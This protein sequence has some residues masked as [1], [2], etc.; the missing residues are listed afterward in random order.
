MGAGETASCL[1]QVQTPGSVAW[2]CPGVGR[3]DECHLK[4]KGDYCLHLAFLIYSNIFEDILFNA[5]FK[6]MQDAY[7]PWIRN[8][9]FAKGIMVAINTKLA[10]PISKRLAKTNITPNQISWIRF[11]LALVAAFFFSFHGWNYHV[12]GAIFF[13]LSMIFDLVDGQVARIKKMNTVFGRYFDL[14]L[15]LVSTIVVIFG[16]C[17]GYGYTNI[18]ELLSVDMLSKIL[19]IKINIWM[20]G[21]FFL[22]ALLFEKHLLA[23]E[24][25]LEE[26]FKIERSREREKLIKKHSFLKHVP[27]G[28]ITIDFRTFL[29]WGSVVINQ[30]VLFLLL[31]SFIE[32]YH[33]FIRILFFWKIAKDIKTGIDM[34]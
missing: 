29:I 23:Y 7:H 10:L 13:Q 22:I 31:L 26:K 32:I 15:D 9:I 25:Y 18:P 1:E 6:C 24:H 20:V 16:I 17:L 28:G 2:D 34:V 3:K 4:Q 11:L 14:M 27:K 30:V 33:S 8:N 19:G 21:M 12:I 5:L